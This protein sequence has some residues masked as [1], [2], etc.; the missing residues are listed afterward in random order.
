MNNT[1]DPTAI[2][3]GKT[4]MGTPAEAIRTKELHS[5]ATTKKIL[6]DGKDGNEN[7]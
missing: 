4:L 1:I 2:F 7:K 3:R 6:L 5:M